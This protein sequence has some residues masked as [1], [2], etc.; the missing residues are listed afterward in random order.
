MFFDPAK[1]DIYNFFHF[2]FGKLTPH[3]EGK[4]FFHT[5][6]VIATTRMLRNKD[7]VSFGGCLAS[8]ILWVCRSKTFVYKIGGVQAQDIH[9][10]RGNVFL[11]RFT[12]G[13]FF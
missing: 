1:D 12:E 13:E 8:I 5:G 6:S 11:F 4:K 3:L 10:S 2:I 7:G 9:S